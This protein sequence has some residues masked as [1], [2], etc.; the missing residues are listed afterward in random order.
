MSIQCSWIKRVTQHWGDNWRYDL[1]LAC[2]GNPLIA[3]RNTFDRNSH[4]ILYN[5]CDSFGKFRSAFTS[6]D[7]NYK[8]S[9][10]FKN[11][12]F[13]VGGMTTVFYVRIFLEQ[14]AITLFAQ[15]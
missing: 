1:K 11:P 10:I 7:D 13:S 12:F 8:K 4:P 5:I 15:N 14:G 6:K 3:D 9:I 2:Y